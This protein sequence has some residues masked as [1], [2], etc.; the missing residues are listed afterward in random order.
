M[1]R[2]LDPEVIIVDVVGVYDGLRQLDILMLSIKWDASPSSA[3]F[4]SL[5]TI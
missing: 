4:A 2:F 1:G 5:V 3:R